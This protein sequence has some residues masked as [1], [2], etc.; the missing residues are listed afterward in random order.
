MQRG[1]PEQWVTSP[2]AVGAQLHEAL[3]ALGPAARHLHCLARDGSDQ[4][5]RDLGRDAG[6]NDQLT[7]RRRQLRQHLSFD[8]IVQDERQFLQDRN[9]IGGRRQRSGSQVNTE[10]PSL[11]QGTDRDCR[12]PVVRR[13]PAGEDLGHLLLVQPKLLG[14]EARDPSSHPDPG[15]IEGGRAGTGDH[16]SECGGPGQE[17]ADL[18]AEPSERSTREVIQHQQP[19]PA[20]AVQRAPERR[21][22]ASPRGFGTRSGR[23]RGRGPTPSSVRPDRMRFQK[24]CRSSAPRPAPTRPASSQRTPFTAPAWPPSGRHP[25]SC[26]PPSVPRP[27]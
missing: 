19:G 11:R 3:G 18:P 23:G 27:P 2:G 24:S 9:R 1:T 13:S 8:H 22:P 10:R 26:P 4:G 7:I 6:A 20:I 12:R 17:S 16:Q 21:E 15:G 25:V 14:S 5:R